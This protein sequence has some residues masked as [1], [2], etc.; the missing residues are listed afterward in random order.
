MAKVQSL[1]KHFF[2]VKSNA[3]I[4]GIEFVTDCKGVTTAYLDLHPYKR[5]RKRCPFCGKRCHGYDKSS[6]P[7]CWRALDCGGII[8]YFRCVTERVQCPEHGVVTCDVPWAFR[9][10]SF[11]KEFDLQ[12]AWLAKFLPSTRIKDLMRIDWATVG[13]CVRRAMEYLDPESD[14]RRLEGLMY[15]GVDETSYRKGHSYITVVINHA[16]DEVVWVHEGHGKAV[17]EKFFQSLTLEQRK[18]IK[19]ISGDGARWIDDC[20]KDYAPQAKRCVD[21]FHVVQWAGDALDELRRLIWQASRSD[22]RELEKQIAKTQEPK[23]KKKLQMKLKEV[24]AIVKGI[25]NSAYALGKAPE[26]LTSNQMQTL[27]LIAESHA[28][29]YRGYELKEELRLILK[30][31]LEEARHNL[32]IWYWKATHSRIESFVNLAHKIKRHWDNIFN[33]ITLHLSNARVEAT[34]N[35]IK[36]LIRRSYG[37]RNLENMFAYIKLI[38]SPLEVPLPNRPVHA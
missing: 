38:C 10:S 26:N 2:H 35:K 13:R 1:F 19:C 31:P 3:V 4:D 36:L 9:G 11:T 32:R 20:I 5:F 7:R 22:T 17:F 30:M 6:S 33:T 28:K 21:P 37:F 29:L 23:E 25:K 18:A 15:I 24:D 27:N 34:N 12:V 16:T 14:K 8:V